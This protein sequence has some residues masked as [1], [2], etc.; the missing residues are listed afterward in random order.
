MFPPPCK[1]EKCKETITKLSK[2]LDPNIVL[3]VTMLS[4]GRV[5][6]V[7]TNEKGESIYQDT[8]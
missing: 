3:F 6:H 4:D 2:I 1:C 7:G 5:Q 8:T